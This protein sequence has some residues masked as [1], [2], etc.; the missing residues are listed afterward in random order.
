MSKLSIAITLGA[1]ATLYGSATTVVANVDT[2]K[3]HVYLRSGGFVSNVEDFISVT[4]SSSP[5]C[6]T[7]LKSFV[8]DSYY[9]PKDTCSKSNNELISQF[10]KEA[11]NRGEIN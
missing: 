2:P 6:E 1:V 8:C 7:T 5:L 4:F 11:K 9:E 10:I 3:C